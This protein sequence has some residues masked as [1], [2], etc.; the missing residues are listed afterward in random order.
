MRSAERPRLA[1]A[2]ATLQIRC[3]NCDVGPRAEQLEPSGAFYYRPIYLRKQ[4]Q[5][6]PDLLS[7]MSCDN[8]LAESESGF[9]LVPL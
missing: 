5:T 7:V 1:R 3:S 6:F 2:P 4:K 8:K 9:K